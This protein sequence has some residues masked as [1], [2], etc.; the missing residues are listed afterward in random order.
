MGQHQSPAYRV[1][2]QLTRTRHL[3]FAGHVAV[4]F[5]LGAALAAGA[6]ALGFDQGTLIAALVLGLLLASS[7]VG[8]DVFGSRAGA[9]KSWDRVLVS[10]LLAATVASAIAAAGVATAVFGAATA[11]Q[12]TLLAFTHYVPERRG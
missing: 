5:A 3:S 8:I 12:A 6:V 7:A 11:I 2:P 9:H 10:L 1:P 4:E